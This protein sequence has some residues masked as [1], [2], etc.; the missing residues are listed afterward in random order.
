M[1]AKDGE[2]AIGL[3]PG[4]ELT[5]VVADVMGV[6][7]ADVPVDRGRFASGI[8]VVAGGE[9]EV[10]PPRID[11]A[12]D[13]RCRERFGRRLVGIG[14]LHRRVVVVCC[15]GALGCGRRGDRG[16][17]LS[18]RGGRLSL[19]GSWLHGVGGGLRGRLDDG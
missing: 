10:G 15:K 3:C 12:G 4:A 6:V 19:R 13:L 14:A 18:L 9:N 5:A 1:I 16:G 2:E 11:E 17:C 7:P 8:V